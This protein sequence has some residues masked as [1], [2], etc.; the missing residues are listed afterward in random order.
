[1]RA[2]KA[3]ASVVVVERHAEVG[4]GCTHWSTIPSKALR[5]S[6]SEL[7][8]F[9]RSAL[10]ATLANSADITFPGLLRAA[11]GVIQQQVAMRSD[12]YQRN[13]VKLVYG[14]ARFVDAHTLEVM[15]T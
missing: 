8:R 13:H 14:H 11:A 2:R 12:F 3:G 4:G 10:F 5:H 7:L 1:M 15:G 9:R 6:V